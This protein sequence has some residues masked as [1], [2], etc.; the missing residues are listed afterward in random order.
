MTQVFS[1]WDHSLCFAKRNRDMRGHQIKLVKHFS[2]TDLR[3]KFYTQTKM[4]EW[5]RLPL[6]A[7]Q[8]ND[9]SMFKK[10]GMLRML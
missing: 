4:N 8:C 5:N 1:K 7:I 3:N 10:F 6:A 9:M 2:R